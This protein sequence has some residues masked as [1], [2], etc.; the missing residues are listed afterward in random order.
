MLL[1]YNRVAVG[2]GLRNTQN[3]DILKKMTD[4]IFAKREE[5]SNSFFINLFFNLKKK[6]FY[7]FSFNQ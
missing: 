2:R 6:L 7:F 1:V 5:I 3:K 4:L